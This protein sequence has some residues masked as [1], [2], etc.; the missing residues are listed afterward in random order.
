MKK[1]ANS[2]T[3]LPALSQ[4]RRGFALFCALLFTTF[5]TAQ[6][7]HIHRAAPVDHQAQVHAAGLASQASDEQICP[8]C[9]AAHSVL[10]SIKPAFLGLVDTVEQS[11]TPL[12]IRRMERYWHFARLSRPPP[13]GAEKA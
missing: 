13:P 7:A 2:Q 12:P 5:S 9:A 4:W 10:P 8:L 11:F 3:Y 6:A 1:H